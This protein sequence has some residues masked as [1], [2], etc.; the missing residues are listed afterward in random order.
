MR[1]KQQ[2]NILPPLF[3][4]FFQSPLNIPRKSFY[5]PLMHRPPI[6]HTPLN[7]PIPIT[8][9]L[10]RQPP[11]KPLPPLPKFIQTTP[12]RRARILGILRKR[13]SPPTVSPSK[14]VFQQSVVRLLS[15]RV[16]VPKRH[17][18][19]VGCRLRRKFVE[20]LAH[21]SVLVLRPAPDGRA[22]ANGC[23]L[24]LDFGGAALGD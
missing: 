20:E 16:R 12:R 24:G 2:H 14:P 22:P 5:Q 6:N 18:R 10:F 11:L 23:V 19:F 13:H 7:Q 17:V 21:L 1:R 9:L 8:S 4:I 3:R 15:Q